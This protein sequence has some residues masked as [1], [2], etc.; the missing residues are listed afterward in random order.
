MY[1]IYFYYIPHFIRHL[2]IIQINYRYLK[3]SQFVHKMYLVHSA[4]RCGF[5]QGKA[6]QLK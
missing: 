2:V 1:S 6:V 4:K 3:P 5:T